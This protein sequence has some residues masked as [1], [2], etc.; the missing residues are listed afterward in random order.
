VG[1]IEMRWHTQEGLLVGHQPLRET[2]GSAA[3]AEALLGLLAEVG[4]ARATVLALP[5]L[6]ATGC[7]HDIA[8]PPAVDA[9][10]EGHD[11][12]RHPWPGMAPRKKIPRDRR[13]TSLPQMPQ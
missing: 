4:F 13:W 1:G 7:R 12:S 6:P 11:F 5:A 3:H 8:G 9:R 10:A 2:P